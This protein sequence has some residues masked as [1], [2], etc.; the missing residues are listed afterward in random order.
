[1]VLIE[2]LRELHSEGGIYI[3]SSKEPTHF[4]SSDCSEHTVAVKERVDGDYDL[5]TTGYN[6]KGTRYNKKKVKTLKA[7][8]KYVYEYLF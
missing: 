8:R 1:M 7:V 3:D 2:L 5:Y 4:L 6:R